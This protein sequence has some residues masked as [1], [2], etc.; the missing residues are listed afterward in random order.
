MLGKNVCF[1][2]TNIHS[3]D[4]IALLDKIKSINCEKIAICML[5]PFNTCVNRNANRDREVPYNIISKMNSNLEIPTKEEGFDFI[6][7]IA[8]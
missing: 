1:D 2:A 8:P 5:P 3:K 4:R 7:F 6:E